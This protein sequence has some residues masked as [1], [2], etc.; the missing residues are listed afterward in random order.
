MQQLIKLEEDAFSNYLDAYGLV[1]LI[2]YGSVFVLYYQGKIVGTARYFRSWQDPYRAHLSTL[3][4]NSNYQGLGLASRLLEYTLDW[5]LREGIR[6]VELT[7]DPKNRAA[8]H[9]YLNKFNFLLKG[10]QEDVYGA[11]E[12]RLILFLSLNEGLK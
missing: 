5:L 2:M 10:Y 7:V 12:D 6:G 3:I 11:G 1:P 8:C 4:I 9:L